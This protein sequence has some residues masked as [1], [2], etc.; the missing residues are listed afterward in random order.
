MLCDPLNDPTD[1]KDYYPHLQLRSNIGEF[2]YCAQGHTQVDMKLASKPRKQASQE[3]GNDGK[4][5]ERGNRLL[6]QR[7]GWVWGWSKGVLLLGGLVIE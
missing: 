4:Q 6:E 2:E 7:S 1:K 3:K 5:R